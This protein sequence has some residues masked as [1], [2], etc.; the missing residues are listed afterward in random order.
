MGRVSHQ[1]PETTQ[2]RSGSAPIP[3]AAIVSGEVAPVKTSLRRKPRGLDRGH[4]P[5]KTNTSWGW[6]MGALWI[7]R[8]YPTQNLPGLPLGRQRDRRGISAKDFVLDRDGLL[9]EGQSIPVKRVE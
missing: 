9:I 8:P 6:G 3:P 1:D 7:G 2:L 4:L 5:A